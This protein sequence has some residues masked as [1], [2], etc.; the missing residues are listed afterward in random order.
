ML[1]EL[2]M[3][4]GN[5]KCFS[6]QSL[7]WWTWWYSTKFSKPSPCLQSCLGSSSPW[8]SRA[9]FYSGIW[10]IPHNYF[11]KH[12][13]PFSSTLCQLGVLLDISSTKSWKDVRI[14]FSIDERT[15]I[16]CEC[17]STQSYSWWTYFQWVFQHSPSPLSWHCWGSGS[18]SWRRRRTQLLKTENSNKPN[19]YES[20][21]F[22]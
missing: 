16:C 1:K 13:C 5:S 9:T 7:D 21:Y 14:R 11:P 18:I 12:G 19:D 20:V 6:T 3:L 22:C 8:C 10:P 17:W 2:P 4:L 15:R